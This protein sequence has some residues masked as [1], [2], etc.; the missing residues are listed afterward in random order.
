VVELVSLSHWG[1]HPIE[2]NPPTD[3]EYDAMVRHHERYDAIP[4][5]VTTIVAW[6]EAI[7]ATPQDR[8][9]KPDVRRSKGGETFV[10]MITDLDSTLQHCAAVML[11]FRAGEFE[12][13][14]S[15]LRDLEG[16]VQEIK[17]RVTRTQTKVR[18]PGAPKGAGRKVRLVPQ[19]E[20]LIAEGYEPRDAAKIVLKQNGEPS[21]SPTR[22]SY[23]LRRRRSA[24]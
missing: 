11:K 19:V 22:I 6:I 12:L 2:I 20:A 24:K 10:A 4:L 3:D 9:N 18:G 17:K 8:R 23:L 1:M 5:R 13:A 14:Q 15:S 21:A 16:R 7:K